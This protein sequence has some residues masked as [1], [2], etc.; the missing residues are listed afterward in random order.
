MCSL[1]DVG[2]GK[3]RLPEDA[4]AVQIDLSELRKALGHNVCGILGMPYLKSRIMQVDFDRG[5]LSF[6]KS[7]PDSAG[8]AC[9]LFLDRRE[10]PM[11][12]IDIS[13]DDS[14]PFVIDTGLVGVGA[15]LKLRS[16]RFDTVYQQ[17][18][19]ELLDGDTR[20][21][22]VEGYRQ[23]RRGWL[24]TLALGDATH[25]GIGVIEGN[26]SALGLCFL[27]R[28]IATFDFPKQQLYLKPGKRVAEPDRLNLSGLGICRS[29]LDGVEIAFVNPNSPGSAAELK[30]G[31]RILKY[32]G[33][34]VSSISLFKLRTLLAT[35]GL[36]I[37]LEVEDSGGSREVTLKLTRPP[38]DASTKTQA[39]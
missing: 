1:R 24:R 31:D 11:L 25:R 23:S 28:Y 7:V 13:E 30:A 4:E 8:T 34:N 3:A 5:K 14:I 18:V 10:R 39:K 17:G 26:A 21:L 16:G 19:I 27:S 37:K 33:K 32:D 2:V 38:K 15:A 36:R 22:S 6:L 35:E 9:R 20:A 12:S 29:G